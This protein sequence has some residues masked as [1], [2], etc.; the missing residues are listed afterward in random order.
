MVDDLALEEAVNPAVDCDECFLE[1]KVN[2]E[3]DY[4]ESFLE[5]TS[6]VQLMLKVDEAPMEMY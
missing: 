6:L 5:A 1:G 4:E 2:L 3:V